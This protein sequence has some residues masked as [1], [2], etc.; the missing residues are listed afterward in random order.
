MHHQVLEQFVV[1][2]AEYRD[3]EMCLS[4][5]IT[6]AR[7]CQS[8]TLELIMSGQTRH[9]Q[10]VTLCRTLMRVAHGEIR[11]DVSGADRNVGRIQSEG[12]TE[13]K[14]S[15]CHVPE[16]LRRVNKQ[17]VPTIADQALDSSNVSWVQ[18]PEI[19]ERSALPCRRPQ[20]NC[21]HEARDLGA[22]RIAT[23]TPRGCR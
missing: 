16:N 3:H 8:A 19:H 10:T 2:F 22:E 15:K 1:W 6:S 18:S 12:S 13:S 11:E 23:R 14:V 20:Q 9:V 4:F 21:S 7:W 17:L 5:A